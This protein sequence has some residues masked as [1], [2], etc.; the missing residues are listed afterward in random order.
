MYIVSKQ[1]YFQLLDNKALAL[2]AHLKKL[3]GVEVGG[4][5]GAGGYSELRAP[6]LSTCNL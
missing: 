3:V 4:G 1:A 2:I 5:D 6:F